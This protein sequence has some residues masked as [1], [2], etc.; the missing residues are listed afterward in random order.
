MGQHEEFEFRGNGQVGLKRVPELCLNSKQGL[1]RHHHIIAWS[2][3]KSSSLLSMPPANERFAF[4]KEFNT[5][6]SLANPKL[7]FVVQGAT[8]QAGNV[9]VLENLA[10]HDEL[11]LE[12]HRLP[13]NVNFACV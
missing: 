13:T 12:R 5:I 2:C 6:Y 9:V 10:P 1:G 3:A 4:D 8:V 11:C 7:V